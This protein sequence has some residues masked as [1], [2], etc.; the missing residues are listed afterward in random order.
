MQ[1]DREGQGAGGEITELAEQ[2][3]ESYFTFFAFFSKVNVTRK[4]RA[5]RVVH[6]PANQ[7]AIEHETNE[8]NEF[9]LFLSGIISSAHLKHFLSVE[10]RQRTR[11]GENEKKGWRIEE[12]GDCWVVWGKRETASHSTPFHWLWFVH[13]WATA[14]RE[15][16]S[17]LEVSCE[18]VQSLHSV[19]WFHS[20][21]PVHFSH[22]S[23]RLFIHSLFSF[24]GDASFHLFFLQAAFF[25]ALWSLF[26]IVL[27]YWRIPR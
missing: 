5:R 13:I 18:L 15:S 3:H 25:R 8:S 27:S 7:T 26:L 10:E 12:T 16:E 17:E 6:I 4:S 14:S 2:K 9:L 22:S 20:S 23:P 11:E 19:D 21:P 1:R 24:L